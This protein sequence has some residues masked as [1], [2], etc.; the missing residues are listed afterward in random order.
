MYKTGQLNAIREQT[1]GRMKTRNETVLLLNACK[2][3]A[4]RGLNANRTVSMQYASKIK[5]EKTR[6]IQ[7]LFLNAL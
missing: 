5:A 1:K 3:W 7:L 2:Y 4:K 6:K